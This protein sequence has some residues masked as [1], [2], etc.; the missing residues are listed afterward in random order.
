MRRFSLALIGVAV[1]FSVAPAFAT[2]SFDESLDNSGQDELVCVDTNK[3]GQIDPENDCCM[4]GGVTVEEATT[5]VNG[6][7]APLCLNAT[8]SDDTDQM[9][10]V[11]CGN[12]TTF[13]G[14]ATPTSFTLEN[15]YGNGVPGFNGLAVEGS[16]GTSTATTFGNSIPHIVQ[17]LV[18][19]PGG[20]SVGQGHLCTAGG[21]AVEV[22]DLGGMTFVSRFTPL[23]SN[24]VKYLC[25]MAPIPLAGGGMGMFNVCTPV[26]AANNSVISTVNAATTPMAMIPF[27]NG[28]A[29]CTGGRM[30]PT[31]SEL[32][33]IGLA[34]ALLG[35][36]TWVLRRRAS[37][38]DS[39]GV[40]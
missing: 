31:A 23:T 22:M 5:S 13:T 28:L 40:A 38:G 12:R 39:L 11:G 14:S 24:L 10:I 27:G 34:L 1:V 2:C 26:D 35:G 21:P 37:F 9:E 17:V 25:T 6:G 15:Q 29:P 33:L 19:A 36:G 32:G 8:Q 7:G 4:R 3:D 18:G 20:G 16:D 30:A